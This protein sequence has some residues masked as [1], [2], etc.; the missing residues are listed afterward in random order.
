MKEKQSEAL[1]WGF[2]KHYP[3]FLCDFCNDH[4]S[5]GNNLRQFL[6]YKFSYLQHQLNKKDNPDL[7]LNAALYLTCLQK[8][9]KAYMD[10]AEKDVII[11]MICPVC[12]FVYPNCYEEGDVEEFIRFSLPKRFSE[13]T[14]PR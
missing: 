7:T 9:L 13:N 11:C 2:G 1:S 10:Q 8:K 6:L 3:S 4:L 12:I 5:A 14:Q